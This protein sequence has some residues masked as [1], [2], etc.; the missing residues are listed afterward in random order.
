MMTNNVCDD[1]GIWANELT[2]YFKYNSEPEKKGFDVSTYHGGVCDCCGR[3]RPVTEVRDFFNPDF[4]LIYLEVLDR[5]H[6]DYYD[7]QYY[8]PLHPR[9]D[10]LGYLHLSTRSLNYVNKKYPKD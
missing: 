6:K 1:C 9:A 10:D 5:K 3:K 4:K 8:C 7:N 2:C